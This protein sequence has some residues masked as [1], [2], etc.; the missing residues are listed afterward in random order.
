MKAVLS[1]RRERLGGVRFGALALYLGLMAVG[2]SGAWWVAAGSAWCMVAA[3]RIWDDIADRE[4][5]AE[6]A[7]QRVLVSVG[8][9]TPFW[10]VSAAALLA[11]AA[12]TLWLGG[13]LGLAV[14]TG[15]AALFGALYRLGFGA[16]HHW[17]LLKY[18]AMVAALGCSDWTQLALVYLSF[19]IFERIDDREL[20]QAP[21]ATA[22]LSLVLL[23]AGAVTVA[24]SSPE[25]RLPGLSLWGL[26]SGLSLFAQHRSRRELAP[27]F[28]VLSL[29]IGA[30]HV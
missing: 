24:A 5:D 10:W 15:T 17:V 23:A 8:S 2:V 13:P 28:F 22:Q 12:G 20:A 1:W 19:A 25:L 16:K 18:P 26:G 29:F 21:G 9:L 27:V 6:R 7:P 4:R 3:F 11:G 30:T 14:L